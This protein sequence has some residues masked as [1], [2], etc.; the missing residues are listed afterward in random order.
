[1]LIDSTCVV[2]ACAYDSDGKRSRVVTNTYIFPYHTVKQRRI[3]AGYPEYWG[4]YTGIAG[5]AV[6]DYEMDPELVSDSVTRG[7]IA[8]ALF[9]IPTVSLS[10]NKSFL[11]STESHP[12]SGG[13]YIFTGAPLTNTTNDIGFGWERAS[14]FELFDSSD[15][16]SVQADCALQLHGGHSR[17]AEK[18]PKHSLR[19]EFKSKYGPPKLEF[20]IFGSGGQEEF[21]SIVLRAGFNNSWVHHSNSERLN[22]QYIADPWVK[23]THRKMGNPGSRSFFIHLYINGLYW[24]IYTVA[25]RIDDDFAEAYLGG[26]GEN[27]DIIKDYT[28]VDQGDLLAW[29]K[30]MNMAKAGL[31]ANEAYQAI[32]GKN[33]DGTR[34]IKSEALVNPVSLIDYMLLNFFVANSDWDHHNWLAIR[35]K[36]RAGDGFRF[37][38]WDEEKVLESLNANILNENN[39]NCPSYLFQRLRQNAE[40]RRLFAD[41]AQ[42]FLSS[43][44]VLSASENIKRYTK[45]AWQISEPLW[46]ESA[47][48]GDYRRDVHPYQ[49]A[50]PFDL[51]TPDNQWA[52]AFTYTVNTYLNQRNDIFIAQLKAAGLLPSTEAPFF[53]IN[54]IRSGNSEVS[55]G[56]TL[57]I[58]SSGET[59]FTT[60]GDDPVN[61]NPSTRIAQRA[62]KYSG[63]VIISESGVYRART[64]SGGVWS[65]S[66]EIK[67]SVKEDLKDL[68]ITEINYHPEETM[69]SDRKSFE[70]IEIKNTGTS[71]LS[72]DSARLSGGIEYFFPAESVLKPGKFFLIAANRDSFLTENGFIPHGEFSGSL[73]NQGES[74]YL[75]TSN[76]DTVINIKYL[77]QDG[78]PTPPDGEGNTLV[79]REIN[80]SG[81]QNNPMEWRASFHSGGSPGMDD[82]FNASRIDKGVDAGPMTL[83]QNYP[84]PFTGSTWIPFRLENSLQYEISVHDI[85]GQKIHIIEKSFNNAG[86]YAVEWNGRTASGAADPGMYIVTLTVNNNGKL[87]SARRKILI[88]G[89]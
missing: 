45:L 34:N 54:S 88:S 44:E 43:G 21:N 67:V 24:G 7:R 77:K 82:L 42:K 58:V 40:F 66:S 37:F 76:G 22:G 14:S 32:Q 72:I 59:W 4:H 52:K 39:T 85:T 12:D 20:P 8:E 29:N 83:Y 60:D 9:L 25:E 46:A 23:N 70:F 64:Y 31:S 74:I 33:P 19:L 41:R 15:S 36:N 79:P 17:R 47:R 65:A 61:W 55:K 81:S 28:E 86:D 6:A 75:I 2:R 1:L 62:Q 35:D 84:N 57:E 78:W 5:I 11:F 71:T 3:I 27:Y 48:W 56:D 30:M 26:E 38:C 87:Y 18:S 53:K 16:V 80:P 73:S 51:Y 63:K 13:I 49:T 50:G 69:W 89:K 68:K 10:T